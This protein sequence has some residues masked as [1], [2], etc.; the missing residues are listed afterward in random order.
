MRVVSEDEEGRPIFVTKRICQERGVGE[1]K[2]LKR[3]EHKVNA[4]G[5]RIP[6]VKMLPPQLF[7]LSSSIGQRG[8]LSCG[9]LLLQLK[10]LFPSRWLSLSRSA[11]GLVI[12]EDGG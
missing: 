9:S 4:C 11:L 12:K 7:L 5:E 6:E 10:R 8:S 1:R 2:P 3:L